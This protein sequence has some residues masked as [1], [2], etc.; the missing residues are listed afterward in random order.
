M[1]LKPMFQALNK[2]LVLHPTLPNE[3]ALLPALARVYLTMVWEL[4]CGFVV[5]T[6]TSS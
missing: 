5:S 4:R 2:G 1:F 6:C 3:E